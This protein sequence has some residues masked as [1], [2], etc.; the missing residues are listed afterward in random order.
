MPP[1]S[2]I[3]LILQDIAV[4][5]ALNVDEPLRTPAEAWAVIQERLDIFW[6]A[7]KNPRPGPTAY[8]H[9]VGV[10]VA[11]AESAMDL[12][13][14]GALPDAAQT[15]LSQIASR[16]APKV[17]SLHDGYGRLAVMQTDLQDRIGMAMRESDKEGFRVALRSLLAG[18]IV[19]AADLDLRAEEFPAT[20]DGPAVAQAA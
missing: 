14:W 12:Y 19:V 5:T 16:P 18:V 11:C 7:V 13:G 9:L 17:A 15:A 2:L 10:G 3:P 8:R 6:T 4:D 1:E 20:G